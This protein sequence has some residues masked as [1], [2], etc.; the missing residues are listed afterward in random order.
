MPFYFKVIIWLLSPILH[1]WASIVLFSAPKEENYIMK[2]KGK[3]RG[4][5]KLAISN[6]ITIEKLREFS[7]NLGCT[8]NDLVMTL[9]S[10]SCHQYFEILKMI[11]NCK[12]K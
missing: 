6:I 2:F 12:L 7:K 11:E 10:V 5:K 8:V 1:I 3:L 9:L 4:K